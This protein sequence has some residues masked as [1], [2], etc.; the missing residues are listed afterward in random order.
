MFLIL[1]H[2]ACCSDCA[3][4]SKKR[5][6][7][8]F[9]ILDVD[10]ARASSTTSNGFIFGLGTNRIFKL[11]RVDLISASI[12]NNIYNIRTGINDTIYFNRS[13]TNYT[14]RISAG[15][16]SISA[17]LSAIPTAMNALD[18][19][20]YT[21]T[22]NTTTNLV[23]IGGTSTFILNWAT[24][25]TNATET[26]RGMAYELGYTQTDTTTGTTQLANNPFNLGRPDYLYIVIPE[27]Q[28]IVFSG[29]LT[30]ALQDVKSTFVIQSNS[31]FGGYITYV[32]NG[33]YTQSIDYGKAPLDNLVQLSPYILTNTGEQISLNGVQWSLKLR[34]FTESSW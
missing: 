34:V 7:E 19:N 27:L 8:P 10:S 15:G 22:Y 3:D 24:G 1:Q 18:S 16:Y 29:N 17:L 30:T 6:R 9:R 13:S 20:T 5:K 2:M 12:P 4:K 33:E 14:A 25:P 11:K 31:N 28:Q 26:Y 32:D 23:T 21:A